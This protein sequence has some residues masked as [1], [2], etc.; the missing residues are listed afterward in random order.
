MC[1]SRLGRFAR[2]SVAPGH[3][4]Y[5]ENHSP[6]DPARIAVTDR[7]FHGAEGETRT[8]TGLPLPD[9]ESGNTAS[10]LILPFFT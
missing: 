7:F 3:C 1:D 6:S 5:A 10:Y 9:F 2:R 8:L 4:D